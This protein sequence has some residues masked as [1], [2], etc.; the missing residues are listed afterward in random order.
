MGKQS[1]GGA[2]RNGDRSEGGFAGKAQ[3]YSGVRKCIFTMK[4]AC[5]CRD[6]GKSPHQAS[7]IAKKKER[8]RLHFRIARLRRGGSLELLT[9]Q[10]LHGMEMA[11][12]EI[13]VTLF[14][15]RYRFLRGPEALNAL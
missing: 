3:A 2:T 4:S 15:G 7:D 10:A 8:R 1:K 9:D 13:F 12:R 6:A 14:A 5:P 11:I